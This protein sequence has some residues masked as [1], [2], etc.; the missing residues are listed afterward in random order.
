M[1]YAYVQGPPW[2]DRSPE[3]REHIDRF[4]AAFLAKKGVMPAGDWRVPGVG[5][6]AFYKIPV[7][8]REAGED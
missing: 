7:E 2:H 5:Y 6:C 4:V 1:T 3:E 8:R